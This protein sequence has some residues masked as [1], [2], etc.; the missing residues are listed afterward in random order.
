M[1]NNL[2]EVGFDAELLDQTI[3]QNAMVHDQSLSPAIG[4]SQQQPLAPFSESKPVRKDVVHAHHERRP[5]AV[6]AIGESVE[7]VDVDQVEAALVPQSASSPDPRRV[8]RG[9]R[10]QVHHSRSPATGYVWKVRTDAQPVDLRIVRASWPVDD[11]YDDLVAGQQ[12]VLG[13]R[14]LLGPSEWPIPVDPH[15]TSRSR[16]SNSRRN[17]RH[18]LTVC[19]ALAPR[20]PQT[21]QRCEAQVRSNGELARRGQRPTPPRRGPGHLSPAPEGDARLRANRP[22]SRS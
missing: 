8:S 13:Q 22:V 21:P 19:V 20:T 18:S 11:L 7:I 14:Q 16:R 5:I 15:V 1:R 9:S 10:R 6:E 17:D 3:C 12:G 4:A 2:D